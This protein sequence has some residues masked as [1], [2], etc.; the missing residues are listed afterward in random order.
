MEQLSF[1]NLSLELSENIKT[2]NFNDCIIE[3]KQYLPINNKLEIIST[4]ITESADANNFA[5]PIKLD[6]YLFLNLIEAYTNI[7]FTDEEKDDPCRLF[8]L[9]EESKLLDE[10]IALIPEKEYDYLKIGV[11]E[12]ADAIYTYRHSIL[13][14][15]ESV[16]QDYSSLNLDVSNLQSQ[17]ENTENF[18][19]LKDVLTKLG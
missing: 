9:L 1:S 7:T 17:L 11:R 6:I 19:L 13:G 4:V 2:L 15:L 12:C 10:I 8:D 5:N 14:I 16:S 3:I 18:S